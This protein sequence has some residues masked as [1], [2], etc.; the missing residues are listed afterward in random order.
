MMTPKNKGFFMKISNELVNKASLNSNS[1][2][3]KSFLK[4]FFDINKTNEKTD[5]FFKEKIMKNKNLRGYRGS[6]IK[7][8]LSSCFEKN[9]NL[10]RGSNFIINSFQRN[11]SFIIPKKLLNEKNSFKSFFSTKHS[12]NNI[13]FINPINKNINGKNYKNSK[14]LNASLFL[15]NFY[16]LIINFFFN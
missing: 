12:E 11:K 15:I 10:A 2:F 5:N 4:N 16:F 7:N 3:S 13:S 8:S 6:Y 9:N 14:S 1:S